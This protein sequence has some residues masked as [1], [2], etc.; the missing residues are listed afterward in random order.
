MF[1]YRRRVDEH[2]RVTSGCRFPDPFPRIRPV[3]LGCVASRG[4]QRAL[5]PVGDRG[6]VDMRYPISIEG[7]VDF[8]SREDGEDCES[9]YTLRVPAEISATEEPQ[10]IETVRAAGEPSWHRDVSDPSAPGEWFDLGDPGRPVAI[11]L[12]VPGILA[13]DMN[14]GIRLG[15][16]TGELCS[17]P[18]MPRFTT[19]GA[20][21]WGMT[22]ADAAGLTGRLRNEALRTAAE[23]ERPTFETLLE[24]T[25]IRIVET[26][27][28]FTM[29]LYKEDKRPGRV[30]VEM[31][32][33][34]TESRPVERIRGVAFF[35]KLAAEVR[36][37]PAVVEECFPQE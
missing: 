7:Y 26:G 28:G 9:L 21:L 8:R 4:S 10:V 5:V 18:V 3:V 34:R 24:G 17:I 29:T 11:T 37:N 19:V 27:E 16:G 14:Y 22:L 15:A 32:F 25:S 33:V 36:E 23:V 6:Q 2:V 1:R 13:G 31:A 30:I 20:D 35:E 12:F